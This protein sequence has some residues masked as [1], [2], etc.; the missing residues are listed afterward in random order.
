MG[1]MQ[2]L[3][4]SEITNSSSSNGINGNRS[5]C[6]TR[7]CISRYVRSLSAAPPK[8]CCAES[9]H[10]TYINGGVLPIILYRAIRLSLSAERPSVDATALSDRQVQ[11]PK[12]RTSAVRLPQIRNG[13]FSGL[14]IGEGGPGC[15]GVEAIET[16]APNSGFVTSVNI[17]FLIP[18]IGVL[19]SRAY[20]H[21][22]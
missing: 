20:G 14:L 8:L 5:K 15:S 21:D 6:R 1:E 10:G 7:L 4:Y 18:V 2:G 19:C 17:S 3:V 12:R 16:R 11:N 9:Q 22:L 13:R